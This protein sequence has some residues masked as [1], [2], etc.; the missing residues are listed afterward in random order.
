M[1]LATSDWIGFTGVAL[2]LFAY[3]LNL[4]GRLSKD[5][6]AYLLLNIIGG[7]LSCLASIL[8]RYFPF[9]LLESVW[10]LISVAAL[11]NYYRRRA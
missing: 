1:H 4:V 11:V 6:L 3:L 8:I 7:A 9:V 2:M 5:G 10:T